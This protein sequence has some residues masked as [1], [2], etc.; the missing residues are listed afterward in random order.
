MLRSVVGF[1]VGGVYVP[2]DLLAEFLPPSHRGRFLIYIEFFW[3][4]G[5][6]MVAGLAWLLLPTY[7]WRMLTY[8]T[9]I[10]ATG[11]P[12]YSLILQLNCVQTIYLILPVA[13]LVSAFYLPESPRW[14]VAQG[15]VQEAVDIVRQ[16]AEVNG[17]HMKPFTLIHCEQ[18][19]TYAQSYS[20]HKP[21]TIEMIVMMTI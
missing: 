3:T 19:G 14:L 8:V 1:G 13:S 2:F 12:I 9:A 7:G 5:S 21:S 10:P 16:A 15:R 17:V 18:P 4:I 6:L 20:S 11:G